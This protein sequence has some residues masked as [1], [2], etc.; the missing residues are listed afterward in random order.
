HGINPHST[1]RS[2]RYAR[3]AFGPP[4]TTAIIKT[5]LS[6]GRQWIPRPT[7]AEMNQ[8]YR[9]CIADVW[10]R[11]AYE[12]GVPQSAKITFVNEIDDKAVPP[13]VNGLFTYLERDYIHDVG[14][15]RP[16]TPGEAQA[17][18]RSVKTNDAPYT[19]QGLFKFDTNS[20]IIECTESCSCRSRCIDRVT[21][22]PRQIPIEIFK[23][24]KRGRGVRTAEALMRGQVLGIYTGYVLHGRNAGKLLGERAAYIFQLDMD[25]DPNDTPTTAYSIE[26]LQS[27]QLNACR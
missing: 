9:Q 4:A 18:P 15:P 14:I 8:R 7:D 26:R 17:Y 5:G 27:S 20:K 16:A 22:C 21:Q 1:P 11:I 25:E 24:A 19:S 2:K 3:R 6:Q 10:N 23:T 13:G 12:A